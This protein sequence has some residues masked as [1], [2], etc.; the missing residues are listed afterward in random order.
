MIDPFMNRVEEVDMQIKIR[1]IVS[2]DR[3]RSKT[4]G[5]PTNR[6]LCSSSS[7]WGL[8]TQACRD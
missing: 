3:F 5:A 2:V 4:V 1:G 6:E 8:I 7:P